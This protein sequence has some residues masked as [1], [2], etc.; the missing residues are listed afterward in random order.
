VRSSA[1]S[2]AWA[3]GS[4]D[5]VLW[6]KSISHACVQGRATTLVCRRGQ[7][8]DGNVWEEAG[9]CVRPYRPACAHVPGKSITGAGGHSL[10]AC[11]AGV[12]PGAP[13]PQ[14]LGAQ[15]SR[16]RGPQ[17]PRPPFWGAGVTHHLPDPVLRGHE[18]VVGPDVAVEDAQGVDLPQRLS[19][20][21]MRRAWP[22]AHRKGARGAQRLG[23]RVRAC[24]A[25]PRHRPSWPAWLRSCGVRAACPPA[26]QLG[27]RHACRGPGAGP[28]RSRW[29]QSRCA[30]RPKSRSRTER[31]CTRPA[32][33]S[34][35]LR[36][37]VRRKEGGFICRGAPQRRARHWLRAL[38]QRCRR[39]ACRGGH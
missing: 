3:A 29:P 35:G 38:Q 1:R 6:S 20:R 2:A 13:A 24:G 32:A 9:A 22:P 8:V 39:G 25:T 15:G 4:H 34:G 5:S 37:G 14:S 16:Q 36:S 23:R 7:C 33:A 26:P 21:V 27:P 19:G 18:H 11:R 28:P 10:K 30:P 31:G 17:K 12:R